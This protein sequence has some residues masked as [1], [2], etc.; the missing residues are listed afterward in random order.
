MYIWVL[1]YFQSEIPGFYDPCVGEPKQLL[2]EYTYNNKFHRVILIENEKETKNPLV[3]LPSRGKF[4]L[5]L[6]LLF[7][8]FIVIYHYMSYLTLID[9]KVSLFHFIFRPSD[10]WKIGCIALAESNSDLWSPFL[11]NI[12]KKRIAVNNLCNVI[13]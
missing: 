6:K 9:F 5:I 12:H 1:F 7:R 13:I 10:N 3:T 4:D 2:I 11:N 8:N